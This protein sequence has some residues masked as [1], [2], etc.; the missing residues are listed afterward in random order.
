MA[1]KVVT[2]IATADAAKAKTG[3]MYTMRALQEG[4]LEDIRLIFFG[5]AEKALLANQDIQG[6][7]AQI[8]T[9]TTPLACKAISD[10][11]GTSDQLQ[12]LGVDVVYVGRIISDLINQG[13]T[14]M[15]W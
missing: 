3:V 15:V 9:A 5:P 13:Y 4:W 2:I 7:V 1:G 11:E 8:K 10:R 6:M 14:P 12:A